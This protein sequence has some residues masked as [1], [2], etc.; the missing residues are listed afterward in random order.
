VRGEQGRI[1][2]LCAAGFHDG[3]S[4]GARLEAKARS[5]ERVPWRKRQAL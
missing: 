3:T 5:E 4:I 1:G 2:W